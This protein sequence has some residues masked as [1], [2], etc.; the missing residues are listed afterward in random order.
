[1]TKEK[2]AAIAAVEEKAAVIADVL[3]HGFPPFEAWEWGKRG[4]AAA[5][6]PRL[7]SSIP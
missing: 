7:S 1:M 3:G 4:A 6:I 5:P 2:Q